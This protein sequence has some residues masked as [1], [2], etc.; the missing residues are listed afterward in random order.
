MS[1]TYYTDSH[2]F[3]VLECPAECSPH[4]LIKASPFL[5][6]MPSLVGLCIWGRYWVNCQKCQYCFLLIHSWMSLRLCNLFFFYPTPQCNLC[7]VIQWKS[8]VTE[9]SWNRPLNDWMFP[10]NTKRLHSRGH[11]VRGDQASCRQHQFL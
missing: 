11:V 3:T 4:V 8:Y 7:F 5:Y 2:S 6:I 10:G 9:M 1:V